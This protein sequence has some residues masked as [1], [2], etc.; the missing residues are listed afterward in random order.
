MGSDTSNDVIKNNEFLK[1]I[2]MFTHE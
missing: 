2:N 1:T